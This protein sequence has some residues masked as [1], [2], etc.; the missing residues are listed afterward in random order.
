L[1]SARTHSKR[2]LLHA[3]EFLFEEPPERQFQCR[4][5]RSF[6]FVVR[7]GMRLRFC[8]CRGRRRGDPDT[9]GNVT[10]EFATVARSINSSV[11]ISIPNCL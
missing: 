10:P 7:I 6:W 11:G 9:I 1:D 4:L 3:I 2:A 5:G 8:Q